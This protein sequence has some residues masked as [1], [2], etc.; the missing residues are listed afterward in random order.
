LISPLGCLV[1]L[2]ELS[3]GAVP[4]TGDAAED[5]VCSLNLPIPSRREDV[6]SS[7]IEGAAIDERD[8]RSIDVL[9]R[10]LL[11]VEPVIS[12]LVF[13]CIG[14][15]SRLFGR[16]IISLPIEGAA[17]RLGVTLPSMNEDADERL[18]CVGVRGT[19]VL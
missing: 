8:A 2:L 12:E 1:L 19:E 9:G 3:C 13:L 16:Y 17:I 7:R 6:V 18:A 14:G 10:R 11:L 5:L 4:E 15:P